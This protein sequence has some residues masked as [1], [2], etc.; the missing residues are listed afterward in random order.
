MPRRRPGCT[1][2]SAHGWAK[3]PI[4]SESN[5]L[6]Q[7]QNSAAKQPM[8]R[9]NGRSVALSRDRRGLFVHSNIC[10][11]LARK[12]RSQYLDPAEGRAVADFLGRP[13]STGPDDC[14]NLKWHG[15]DNQ[16]LIQRRPDHH[17]EIRQ[18]AALQYGDQ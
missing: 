11:A 9:L 16:Y 1:R 5:P 13:R 8:T 4:L 3:M 18:P 10:L 14:L 6:S 12:K 7:G 2:S 17:Q 15:S